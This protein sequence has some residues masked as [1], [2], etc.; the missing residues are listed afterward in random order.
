MS[1]SLDKV[2]KDARLYSFSQTHK[3]PLTPNMEFMIFPPFSYEKDKINN[4]EA[5]YTNTSVSSKPMSGLCPC[6]PD[7]WKPRLQTPPYVARRE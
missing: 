2:R 4:S 3:A 6:R 1:K 7:A 5:S